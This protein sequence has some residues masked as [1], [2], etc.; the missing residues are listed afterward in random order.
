MRKFI[1]YGLMSLI[2]A[3]GISVALSALMHALDAIIALGAV[4]TATYLLWEY[5]DD[6]SA[7]QPA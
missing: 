1:R 4:G 7:I 3:L 5:L 6:K 2:A